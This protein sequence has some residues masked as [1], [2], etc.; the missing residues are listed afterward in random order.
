[1]NQ[2]ILMM[3]LTA[4]SS[5]AVANPLAEYSVPMSKFATQPSATVIY[6]REVLNNTLQGFND[7]A[8]GPPKVTGKIDNFAESRLRLIFDANDVL[9]SST[10]HFNGKHTFDTDLPYKILNDDPMHFFAMQDRTKAMDSLQTIA[11]DRVTGTLIWTS[12]SASFPN[13]LGAPYAESLFFVCSPTD[14]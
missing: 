8:K 2:L 14:D 11:I 13:M 5:S 1:M 7:D 12:L 4:V 3:L 6:C 10:V 9:V